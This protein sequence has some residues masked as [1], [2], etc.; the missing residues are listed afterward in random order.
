[1]H[2]C[3]DGPTGSVV[4][5]SIVTEQGSASL[6]L[7]EGRSEGVVRESVHSDRAGFRLLAGHVA[8]AGG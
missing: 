2:V 1:M 6:D 4:S 5:Q 3:A 7:A 8:G